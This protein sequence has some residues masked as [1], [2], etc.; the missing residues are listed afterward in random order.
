VF[1]L[2]SVKEEQMR[3]VAVTQMRES[4]DH[5]PVQLTILAFIFGAT[6]YLA[7]AAVVSLSASVTGF[8]IWWFAVT[9]IMLM[10]AASGYWAFGGAYY[11]KENYRRAALT[12][13]A[14]S[15]SVTLGTTALASVAALKF[16]LSL[17]P[18][19]ARAMLFISQAA[20]VGTSVLVIHL[21]RRPALN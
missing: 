17:S 8:S 16:P 13:I 3:P 5:L 9:P 2:L 11:Y 7:N 19:A 4:S 20:A 18:E 14:A 21:S 1:R 10:H 15:V 12:C 6:L